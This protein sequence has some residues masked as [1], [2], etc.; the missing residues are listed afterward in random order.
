MVG[1]V[2]GFRTT[3]PVS[4]RQQEHSS[5]RVR[6]GEGEKAEKVDR[7]Q[8]GRNGG[9][10]LKLTAI[11]APQ[12][13][14]PVAPV[15]PVKPVRDT[16]F[17]REAMLNFMAS[18]PVEAAVRSRIQYADGGRNARTPQDVLRSATKNEGNT[19]L[20]AAR[21]QA[22]WN[23]PAVAG[24]EESLI[25][26]LPGQE[27]ETYSAAGLTGGK[28]PWIPGLPGQEEETYNAAGLTGQK[29][30]EIP[31]LPGQEEEASN[32][33]GMNAEEKANESVFGEDS[34]EEVPGVPESETKS[35][36]EAA[37]EGECQ[38][39]EN[40]KYQDGSDDPGV[41]FKSPT[42][43]APEMAA[44]AVRGHENEHVVREQAKAARE[45]RKVVS[46]SVTYKTAICPE[47]GKVYV[48][49][50]ETRTTTAEINQAEPF[51]SQAQKERE[52]EEKRDKQIERLGFLLNR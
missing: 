12:T 52:E 20:S 41:S 35:A 36:Q 13:G 22:A 1:A 49:G 3:Y 9:G 32:I 39:C 48:S 24:E 15:D 45:G 37:E 38:T 10:S 5:Q 8:V 7:K 19:P 25:P 23:V 14:K 51:K 43:V 4:Y 18:D 40:R 34:E 2:S 33:P 11:K 27:E 16:G 6:R 29:E 30:T 17:D 28:E 44:A 47:C 42:N 31:G 26:G 46:Q 50:G 21:G